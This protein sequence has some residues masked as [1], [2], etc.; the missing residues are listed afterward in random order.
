MNG[1]NFNVF[2]IIIISGVLHGIIFSVI[3]L[4]QK[5][6]ITNNTIYLGLTVL[7]L[8][9]SN[10]QYWLIDTNITNKY[11]FLN[12]IFIPWQWLIL[13]MFY[14]YVHKFIGRKKLSLKKK[15]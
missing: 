2:N 9:L 11:Q 12:Y 4:S 15:K 14:M 10:F 5:K 7:F 13:P 3:V 6:N 8:S 1:L